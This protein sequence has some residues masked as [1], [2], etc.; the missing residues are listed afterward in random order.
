MPK[1]PVVTPDGEKI[2]EL[3]QRKLGITRPEDFARVLKNPKRH[4]QTLRRLVNSSQ[5]AGLQFMGQVAKALDVD[6]TEIIV[7]KHSDAEDT[8]DSEG[9][10][11]AS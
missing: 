7:I 2:R 4:P 9:E 11:L 6:V 5:P 3:L 8:D 10:A 1:V